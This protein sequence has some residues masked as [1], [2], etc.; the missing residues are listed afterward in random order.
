GARFEVLVVDRQADPA[1]FGVAAE[2][3]ECLRIEV[4]IEEQQLELGDRHGAA[5]PGARDRLGEAAAKVLLG[6]AHAAPVL[7]RIWKRSYR[8]GPS[9]HCSATSATWAPGGPSRT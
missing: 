2:A 5:L 8:G 6:V 4:R 3:R 1:R 9:L 7:D